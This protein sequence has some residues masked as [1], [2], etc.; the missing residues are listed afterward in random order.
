MGIVSLAKGSETGETLYESVLERSLLIDADPNAGAA[1]SR[2]QCAAEAK[3][4]G[5]TVYELQKS[6]VYRR[7]YR[8]K[9]VAVASFSETTVDSR[10]AKNRIISMIYSH[11]EPH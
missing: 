3:S 2:F 10:S 4:R 9:I 8:H 5:V 11:P 6:A 7:K 1:G